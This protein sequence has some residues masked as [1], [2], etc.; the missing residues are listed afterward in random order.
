MHFGCRDLLIGR[1]PV[2]IMSILGGPIT[3]SNL[4]LPCEVLFLMKSCPMACL[5]EAEDEI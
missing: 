1:L 3:T 4:S 5:L 2:T